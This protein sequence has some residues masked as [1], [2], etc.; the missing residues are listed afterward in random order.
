MNQKIYICTML[1]SLFAFMVSSAQLEIA[2]DRAFMEALR[3]HNKDGTQRD[4]A[5]DF[6]KK[7]G[8]DEEGNLIAEIS[9]DPDLNSTIFYNLDAVPERYVE[10][11]IANWLEDDVKWGS[12]GGFYHS[13][14]SGILQALRMYVRPDQA[15]DPVSIKYLL[16]VMEDKK[17]RLE[18]AK[19]LRT[20]YSEQDLRPEERMDRRD[21]AW[22]EIVKIVE[23]SYPRL[24]EEDKMRRVEA[25]KEPNPLPGQF[26]KQL[27]EEESKGATTGQAN[28]EGSVNTERRIWYLITITIVPLLICI[29]LLLRA[30]L[31]RSITRR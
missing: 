23:Q 20:C 12:R 11:V 13:P 27:K 1:L 29:G 4:F 7:I 30:R 19:I 10:L 9:K 8:Q 15:N 5:E 22:D 6:R 26:L 3:K 18:M 31:K 16:F 24:L 25:A 28:N 21:Q 2:D 14:S 17:T